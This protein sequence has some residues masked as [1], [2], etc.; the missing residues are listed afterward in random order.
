MI[1]DLGHMLSIPRLETDRPILV[2]PL[3]WGAG[4]ATRCIPLI[5]E[6]MTSGH[7]VILASDGLALD[8]L[9][10]HFPDLESHELPAWDMS[11][12]RRNSQ[13]LS[14]LKQLPKVSQAIRAERK[15]LREFLN[16]RTLGAVIS[17]NR[18]GLHDP[19]TLSILLTH[20][21]RIIHPASRLGADRQLKKLI[22]AFDQCWIP[23]HI[24]QELSGEL[25]GTELSIPKHF[26]GPLSRM[27]PL[28]THSSIPVLAVLSGIE[29][30]RSIMEE[31][32]LDILTDI[33]GSVL[34]SG[35]KN[36]KTRQHGQ[37]KV[38]PFQSADELNRMIAA[39]DII[40]CRSGYST[41]MD[42]EAVG[43][44]AILVPT[45]GQPEQ[46]YLAQ[47][48]HNRSGFRTVRQSHL[49]QELLPLLNGEK[50]N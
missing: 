31:G 2:A 3:N 22:E 27:V 14:I 32:L 24:H 39:S 30:Q 8:I 49:A 15:W 37:C 5:N 46:E 28:H 26:I 1:R 42:L 9:R 38:L 16:Q 13:I 4:H 40:I 36:T 33:P 44:T 35:S 21:L 7:E 17:D 29:P 34:V 6:L 12:S 23:D 43:K 41:L 10:E 18:Y 25:S 47:L 45:P 48:H 19:S 11:Y 20:Q 50:I